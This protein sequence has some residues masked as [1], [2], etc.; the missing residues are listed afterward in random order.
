[1]RNVNDQIPANACEDRLTEISS[2]LDRIRERALKTIPTVGAVV[3]WGHV[4]DLSAML[5]RLEQTL[6]EES[7]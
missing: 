6:G 1:M 4:G 3:H 2:T 7:N 5:Y